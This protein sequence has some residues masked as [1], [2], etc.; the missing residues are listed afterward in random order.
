MQCNAY[1]YC[2]AMHKQYN[3]MN[4]SNAYKQCNAMHMYNGY[5]QCNA[6]QWSAYKQWI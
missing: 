1:K 3:G 6:M 5:N 2:N 4:I